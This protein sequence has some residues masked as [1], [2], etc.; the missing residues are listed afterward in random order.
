MPND[1]INEDP[2][3][4][5]NFYL[6]IDGGDK[7]PLT[8]ISGFDV[9][10]DVVDVNQNLPGGQQVHIKTRG[11]TLQVSAVTLS[12]VAPNSVTSDPIWPW[13]LLIREE[14]TAGQRKNGSIV[15]TDQVGKE[16]ARY[17]FFNGWPSKIT[18][19]DM[20][21]GANNHLTEQI[22]LVSERMDRVK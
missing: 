10:V 5:R 15:L 6:E 17:N 2:I 18:T 11:G 7:V 16:L 13:F 9:E 22:T 8:G 14:G 3:I 4:A 19:G 21:V 12:R 1:L 20:E